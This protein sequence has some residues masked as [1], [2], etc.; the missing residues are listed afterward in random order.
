MSTGRLFHALTIRSEKKEDLVE[1]HEFAPRAPV[2]VSTRDQQVADDVHRQPG[3]DIVDRPHLDAGGGRVNPVHAPADRAL[4]FAIRSD[5][6]RYAN[7]FV[8]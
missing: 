1:Q 7:R 2:L 3:R 5:S 6:I 8:G 4:Q